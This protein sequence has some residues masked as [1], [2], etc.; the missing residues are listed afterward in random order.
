M[1]LG[2]AKYKP[3]GPG[4]H[5]RARIAN[6]WEGIRDIQIPH[7]VENVRQAILDPLVID[8]AGWNLLT[9]EDEAQRRSP[10]EMARVQYQWVRGVFQ[11]MPDGVQTE[12]TQTANRFIRMSR[13]P[14]EFI[15]AAVAPIYAARERRDLGEMTLKDIPPLAVKVLGDCDEAIMC[16]AALPAVCGIPTRFMLGSADPKGD[17]FH[18]IWVE[19]DVYGDGSP[20][21]WAAGAMDPT[22][23]EFDEMGKYAEMARYQPVEIFA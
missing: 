6:S 23:P 2:K 8:Q 12:K 5:F 11:Y 14:R 9:I 18:H 17:S 3:P 13:V 15:M 4:E 7:L 10:V 20:D 16:S 19:A 21:S 22:E 1:F